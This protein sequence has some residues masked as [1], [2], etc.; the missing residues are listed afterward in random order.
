M[1]KNTF[2]GG[3]PSSL[4]VPM[5]EVEQEAIARMI[6]SGDL[7]VII[8][9]WGNIE[10]PRV[11][12]GDARVQV[13][14]EMEFSRPTFPQDN[15]FFDLE[16]WWGSELLLRER[17]ATM[18]GGKP[19]QI[20]AGMKMGLAWEIQL[21]NM[22]PKL[23][24]RIVQGATGFTSRLQDKDTKGITLEGNMSLDA[25]KRGKLHQVR[26]GEAVARQD[27]VQKAFKATKKSGGK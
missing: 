1:G 14:W 24:K 25:A 16:L 8:R 10:R 17:Q 7:R 18:I 2:G 20:A 6:E 27:T 13:L 3:N 22:D 12:F 21:Q 23:V 9:E 15:F 5:S 11:T 26:R 19:I 4:Y